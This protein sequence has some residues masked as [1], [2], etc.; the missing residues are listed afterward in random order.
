LG[1]YK[2]LDFAKNGKKE[3]HSPREENQAFSV[4]ERI[5]DPP[6]ERPFE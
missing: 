1:W 6:E 3:I 4:A 2:A 5:A